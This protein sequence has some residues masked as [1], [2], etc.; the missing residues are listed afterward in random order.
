MVDEQTQICLKVYAEDPSRV[1]QDA[2]NERR[3]AQGGYATRQLEEMVQNA[4]DAA[5]RG[6][7][8]IEVLLTDDCLYVAND[9]EPFD[10]AGVRSLMASDVSTK[11]D[12]RIGKFGIGFKSILAV[13][14]VPR[15]FS[16]SVCFGFDKEWAARTLRKEGHEFLHSPTMRLA[17]VL[18]PV[19]DGAARDPQL[20]DM[21]EWASTVI[22]APLSV[23]VTPLAGRLAQFSPEFILF[24]P[25]VHVARLRSLVTGTNGQSP[26]LS[27]ER[28]IIRKE[29]KGG[30]VELRA[31]DDVSVW[32]VASRTIRPSKAAR[33]EAGHVAA[34]ESLDVQYAVRVPPAGGLGS[35]WAYF[36]TQ[37]KTTLSGIVNAPWKLSDDRLYL[38]EGRFNA[39]LLDTL[40]TLVGEAL[41]RFSGTDDAV[42][43][44]DALPSRG[45]EL[46]A[47]EARNWVDRDINGPIFAH[48]REQPIL[49]DGTGRLQRPSDLKWIGEITKKRIGEDRHGPD[50][51]EWLEAW[52][53]VPGAP[54][55][56]WVH[57]EA[58][59]NQE[60]AVKVSRLM[61]G[62][63]TSEAGVTSLG[64]WLETLVQDRSVESSTAAIALAARMMR[65]VGMSRDPALASVLA[66]QI[67][68]ARIIRLEDGSFSPVVRGKVFVR[69][70]GQDHEGVAFVDPVLAAVEGVAGN[71]QELGVVLMDQSG[72]LRKL[73]HEVKQ[74]S[75]RRKE[76]IW[77]HIWTTLRSIPSDTAFQILT[78]DLSAPL[79]DAVHV[80]TGSGE[81]CPVSSAFLG[82][83]LVPH[84]GSRDREFLIDPR[85]HVHDDELL[86]LIGA[87]ELP[88]GRAVSGF[89][90]G[91]MEKW[92]AEWLAEA[93]TLFV[94]N[95]ATKVAPEKVTVTPPTIVSWPLD[96]VS[97][98]SD[99]AKRIVT[100]LLLDRGL[101][102]TSKV[103]HTSNA[104]LGVYNWI[105]PETHFLRRHGRFATSHGS[106]PP[107]ATLMAQ[108]EIDGGV[109]PTIDIQEGAA[110]A[111]GVKTALA[112]LNVHEWE[113]MKATIDGWRTEERDAARSIFYAWLIYV[114][115][116]DEMEVEE[117]VAAVGSQRSLVAIE[118]I[119]VTSSTQTYESMIDSGVP[120]LWVAEEDAQLFVER[121]G[122]PRGED[123][124][125]EEI[126]VDP[127]GESVPLTDAFP[128][129][130]LRLAADDQDLM[131]Q[132]A[133]R[134]VRM[135]A[136]PKGQ[137]ARP[138]SSRRDGDTI[139]VTADSPSARLT[140]ISEVLALGLEPVDINRVLQSMEKTASDKLRTQIKRCNDDDERLVK[141]VGVDALRRTVPAQA[142]ALLDEETGGA[143][144]RELAALARAV[145][146]IAIL[147][148]LRPA[149]EDRGLE[150]PKE[151]AGRMHTRQW[152][153]GLGFPLDWAGFPASQRA[154]VE[155]IEG[156]AELSPLHEYQE[157]VTHRIEA[158]LR[159]AGRDRGMVSLPTGAGKTRVTVEA[160]VNAIRSELIT[161]DRPLIWIAQ[162]DELCEQ[163]AETWT[164]VWR[165]IG[166]QIPMRLGRLWGGNEVSEEPGSFQL[167]I[168]TISKLDGVQ[169]RTGEGYGW[170]REPSVVVIDEAHTSVSPSYTQ[171]LEWM[172]R[173]GRR[174]EEATRRPLIGLTATPFRG[175]SEVESKR[176]VGRYD[177]NRL[178][179]GAFNRED[180]YEELQEMG[181]L[182]QVRHQVLDGVD[183][184][185]SDQD[186]QEIEKMRRLPSAVSERLGADLHR[187]LRVVEH[188]AS[189]PDDWT[190]LAF[191][192][193][194]ESARV[195]AALLAHRGVPAVS[196][197]ADTDAAA[198]RH[199]VEEFKE[200][201][202]RV[203]TN[204]NVLTQGFDAPKV[205]AV[206]VARPTFS[207]NVYQQMIGRGL[208]GPL[209]GGSEEVL[210]VNVEDNF[211]QYGDL[212]AF[213]EF[214][215]LW[216][217]K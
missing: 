57:P 175:N 38:L 5:R 141:A 84:D 193:S 75:G 125:H 92:Y 120:A 2:N 115:P 53:A 89:T 124:L 12:D 17:R 212:L 59:K 111:L 107:N 51:T 160:L 90:N 19:T 20:A 156:P 157:F 49:P 101:P 164:Y 55:A 3:I 46:G 99:E 182:A 190:V 35:F 152:V 215:Y 133:S 130:R 81:W 4:T 50:H 45:G 24:S 67:R 162:T 87:V 37:T 23:D 197:S 122:M 64:R 149:L 112:S 104:A 139:F 62:G 207:P 63:D 185:L 132:P 137:V 142:L 194:V 140:Q 41:R 34:R 58:Y 79:A 143:P 200:G 29:L 103:K 9:G 147:K 174:R 14:D 201:R 15:V 31:G 25:H 214:E 43:V 165:A 187:T 48:L 205:E 176:L 21:M 173:G 195:L 168:A 7:G 145:H 192:P 154:A 110:K 213:N 144:P 161:H 210:I 117:L 159:G 88:Q 85:E 100:D 178:D 52:A 56:D 47:R 167:V 39:E 209:N 121:L 108:E 13:S 73:L 33:V 217:K 203:L 1:V 74:P 96:P 216:T 126:V 196:I 109:F 158:M 135:T 8:R 70:E 78:D 119:G 26:L 184:T 97:R 116:L 128:P 148:H 199:Y 118:N 129:L 22:V 83:R 170:L 211:D 198:R 179:R 153:S 91:R 123:L 30:L 28:S 40:P 68:S 171:A 169:E 150:P 61:G 32:S 42:R 206:Y 155:V 36:P 69:V 105:G 204:Y 82:G 180:P 27:G 177:G 76:L 65:D 44:L 146:G 86:K 136:T 102:A 114:G 94:K 16:R 163:A 11:D 77:P 71:L 188:I 106:R 181:V 80:K 189:L 208:R 131:L 151:W 202:I 93:K 10:A 191:A 127:S 113:A 166:P 138:L 60:L 66:E 183:V 72:E 172:G 54:V 6:G 95:A 186:K 18:D 98:M 134:L